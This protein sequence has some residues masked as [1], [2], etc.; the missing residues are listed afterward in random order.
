MKKAIIILDKSAGMTSFRAC[1][2]V[3]RKVKAKKAG[4][5]GTLDPNVT[6]V[7]LIALNSA[8]KL[9][10]LFERLDKEYKGEAH[11]HKD[12]Q[13]K[14]IKKAIKKKFLGK[15]K[16]IPPQKS[17][18]KRQE[19]ERVIYEFKILRK[20]GKDIVF[21]VKCEAGTYI[22]KL[23]HDLGQE[24]GC[25][26]HMTKLRRINQGPF[27]EKK[28]VKF[29]KLNK[30]SIIAAEK[31]IPKVSAIIFTK[32]EAEQKLKQGKFLIANDIKKIKGNFEK[33]KTVAVFTN[34]KVI[35]LATPFFNSKKIKKEK[36]YVLKPKR[37]I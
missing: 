4:H 10:P 27:S 30:K 31:L 33:E 13:V 5:A 8:T 20:E 7:L 32:K 15:I 28:A 37:I 34:K 9:M 17:R 11:L 35:A 36:G 6:G 18:V 24:L 1:D 21:K 26:A 29:E 23:I 22:R 12:V 3:R 16:Q 14:K 25:G 19:R 2:M